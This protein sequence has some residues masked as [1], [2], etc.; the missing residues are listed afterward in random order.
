MVRYKMYIIYT[1]LIRP[2]VFYGFERW[3]LKQIDEGKLCIVERRI[4]RKIYGPTCV[5]GVWRIKYD[6]DDDDVLY[7][8]HKEPIRVKMI[9]KLD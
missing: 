3:I 8:F 9:T 4:L 6:D 5:N 7:S 2:M 1:M